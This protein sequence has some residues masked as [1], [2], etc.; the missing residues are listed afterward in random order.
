MEYKG[1]I[2]SSEEYTDNVNETNHPESDLVTVISPAVGLVYTG[3]RVNGSVDY[4]GDFRFYDLGRRTNETNNNLNAQGSLDVIG[5]KV[6][7]LDIS[8]TNQMVFNNA[9]LG[10]PTS[11]DTLS[12]Q[13]N[14]NAFSSGL[15]LNPNIAER[16]QTQLG[17]RVSGTLYGSSEDVNKY[18]QSA[19]LDIMHSL[20][21]KV[22][23]GF[24]VQAERQLSEQAQGASSK[25]S[26]LTNYTA[27]AVGR[28]TYGDGRYIFCR[29]GAVDTAYDSGENTLL[30]T[31]SAG[32]THTLGRTV[33]N[34]AT[35]GDYEQN[36]STVY[37]SF[38]STYSASIYRTFDRSTFSIN[39]GYSKYTGKGTPESEDFTLGAGLS[40]ELTQR[41]G[42]NLSVS[43]DNSAP[44]LNSLVR[45]Y[46]SA[47]L[48][49][50]LPK[51]FSLR[52]YFRHKTSL[53]SSAQESQGN[54]TVNTV[55][56]AVR[57]TF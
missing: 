50:E 32:W 56:V 46:A 15:T 23:T 27:T 53:A 8:D 5:D 22:E 34:L 11:A 18:T 54:A 13:T 47:E 30:P 1:S 40:Y 57:K 21:P 39:A 20:T 29:F 9:A 6:L 38:R 7:M 31:W 12:N 14:Q 37:N 51:D 16:T 52:L 41:M 26:Y 42:L 3:N 4:H 55:G 24:N 49:Y 35:Q 44:T 19:F 2:E 17:Y 33:F 25:Q 28:Y 43:T 48:N 36:P 10:Q 45:Y